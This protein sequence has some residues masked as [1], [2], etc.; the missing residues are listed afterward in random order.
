[1]ATLHIPDRNEVISGFEAVRDYLSARGVWHDRWQAAVAFGPDADQATI[2]AAYAHVLQPYMAAHGY[3]T[4]D[5]INV[6]PE[7][8]NLEALRTKFLQEHTHTEDEVRFFVEGQGVFW[9]NLGGDE[10]VVGVTCTP[11]DLLSVPAGIQHWFDLGP[12]PRVK[13]IRLFIDASGWVPHY[14]GTGAEVAYNAQ[15][16]RILAEAGIVVKPSH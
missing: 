15:I 11:G 14:T 10:P 12:V 5:V 8:P 6:T 4:A 7:T 2:L 16:E 3:T 13:A 9:F 1:M